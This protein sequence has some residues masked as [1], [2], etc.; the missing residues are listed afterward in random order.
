M[1]S[2]THNILDPSERIGCDNPGTDSDQHDYIVLQVVAIL[3]ES[4]QHAFSMSV[5]V[6]PKCAR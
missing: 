6:D 5:L 3:S 1:M 4:R 2:R